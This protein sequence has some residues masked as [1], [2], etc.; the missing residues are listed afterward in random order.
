M[1]AESTYFLLWKR[2]P[3][4]GQGSEGQTSLHFLLKKREKNINWKLGKLGSTYRRKKGMISCT[5][6]VGGGLAGILIPNKG[7]HYFEGNEGGTMT[8]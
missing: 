1:R 8:N 5:I 3:M 7:V 4:W 6:I 2:S